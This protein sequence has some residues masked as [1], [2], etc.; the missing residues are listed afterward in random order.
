M[1]FEEDDLL[2]I[3]ALQH[4]VFCER[5]AALIHVER[6]WSD[7]SLTLEGSY[8]HRRV[9][10][11]SPRREVRGDVVIVRG[12]SLRSPELGLV[13]RADVVEFRRLE[14]TARPPE[15]PRETTVT[16]PGLQ[17]E[18]TPYPVEYKRGVPKGNRC[19]EVQ[20]CAQALCLEEQLA[21]GI[22]EGAL[23]YGRRQRRHQVSLDEELRSLT[24][25]AAGRFRELVT[26]GVTPRAT[27]GPRCERCSLLEL[28]LPEAMGA[29][30]IEAY[31]R[32]A[33]DSGHDGEEDLR[34]ADT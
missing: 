17:G 9:D 12:L 7:N 21:V 24:R 3:S 26:E 18:W 15:G 1:T 5:Q 2:P 13:G 16:L 10:S 14:G 30:S 23:F 20:L 29:R 19:D 22:P 28:C 8:S 11:T 4:L 25:R 32:S 27:K 33:L 31:V 6:L 34:C